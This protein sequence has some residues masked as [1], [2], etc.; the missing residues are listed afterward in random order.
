MKYSFRNKQEESTFTCCLFHEHVVNK[1]NA[2]VSSMGKAVK[3]IPF[4]EKPL[5]GVG[6]K[7]LP[8]HLLHSAARYQ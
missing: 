2:K 1:G 8:S 6:S 3:Q 7:L 4:K 5:C